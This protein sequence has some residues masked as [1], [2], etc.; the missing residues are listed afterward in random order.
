MVQ[1]ADRVRETSTST[2]TGTFD[3]GGA[4]SGFQ[5]FTGSTIV[6]GSSVHYSIEHQ[7]TSFDEW[8][9][10]LGTFTTTGDASGELQ[11]SSSR[12]LDT[13]STGSITS[14]SAGTKIVRVSA[15]SNRSVVRDRSSTFT[16][17]QT[18]NGDMTLTQPSQ[19]YTIRQGGISDRLAFERAS[20][21][22]GAGI[23]LAHAGTGTNNVQMYVYGLGSPTEGVTDRERLHI[24]YSTGNSAYI[25]QSASAGTGSDRPIQIRPAQSLAATFRTDGNVAM[26]NSLK[27]GG[28]GAATGTIEATDGTST[29]NVD[30]S[31]NR[32]LFDNAGVTAL[33]RLSSNQ[34]T[35]GSSIGAYEFFWNGTRVANIVGVAGDD[36]TNKD[37]A[38][39]NFRTASAG[40]MSTVGRFTQEGQFHIQTP[41][42]ATGTG[43][44]VSGS[45]LNEIQRDSSSRRYKDHRQYLTPENVDPMRVLE[46]EPAFYDRGGTPEAG[47]YAEDFDWGPFQHG[48][49]YDSE[50]QV[51]GF[52][53]GNR[54]IDAAQQVVLRDHE[55]RISSTEA[56]V[57]ELEREN[58]RLRQ[59]LDEAA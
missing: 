3:L 56:K 39:M 21:S 41:N 22:G 34:D 20:G 58:E 44:V 28:T 46:I 11:R 4:P 31:N 59:R 57:K 25:I 50:G 16:Q 45:G 7:S 10:G 12:V 9:T 19:D 29:F 37:E 40:T 48:L 18:F 6:S 38:D 13:S 36:T 5:K 49:V 54:A 35:T 27:V 14:F 32:V 15:V 53:A 30:F 51:E 17:P 8:E 52:L 26:A 47:F 1:I 42:S 2:G 43:L 24:G 33:C 23:E 55:T